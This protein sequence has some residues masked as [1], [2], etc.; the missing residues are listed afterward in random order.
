MY[1]L[2]IVDDEPLVLAGLKSMIDWDTLGIELAG[3]AANGQQALEIIR[4]G[5]IDLVITDIK[6][7]VLDGMELLDSCRKEMDFCPEFI[8]LT[9]YEEISYLRKAITLDAAAYLIKLELTEDGLRKDLEKAIS[10]LEL[11]QGSSRKNDSGTTGILKNAFFI[12]LLNNVFKEDEETILKE[13]ASAYGLT[14]KYFSVVIAD[15]E[16]DP[17]VD[18]SETERSRVL[19]ST[20]QLVQDTG[21]RKMSLVVLPLAVQRFAIITGSFLGEVENS[22]QSVAENLETVFQ[23]AENYFKITLSGGS[24]RTTDCLKNISLSYAEAR[25]ALLNNHPDS[26]EIKIRHCTSNIGSRHSPDLFKKKSFHSF[27]ETGDGEAI[28]QYFT[29]LI[30]NLTQNRFHFAECLDVSCS[31]LYE[32]SGVLSGADQIL[33][34]IFQKWEGGYKS[35]Y[36]LNTAEQ[37]IEWLG[38]LKEGLFEEFSSRNKDY[39]EMV[40]QQIKHYLDKHYLEKIG[41]NEMAAHFNMSPNYLSTIFNKMNHHGISHYQN[42][43]RIEKAR[44]LLLSGK[45]RIYEISEMTGFDS[46]FYFSKVFKRIT[47]TS[48][49]NWLQQNQSSISGVKKDIIL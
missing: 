38:C 36:W 44:E 28:K 6:M 41:L 47:G 25:H 49:K 32:V 2:L 16:F 11:R 21:S 37:I 23:Q 40:C 24:G 29:D 14:G 4:Q 13:R 5:D 1:R 34:Q 42:T 15:I 26:A 35:I 30:N 9:S 3:T 19:I 12:R 31:L 20:M 43:R 18:L 48:P 39:G 7:P 8:V 22:D 27:L 17:D 46:P 10:E 33:E 45:Y